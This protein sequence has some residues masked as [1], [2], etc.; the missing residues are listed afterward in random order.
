M[1]LIGFFSWENLEGGE[2]SEEPGLCFYRWL[3]ITV[4]LSISFSPTHSPHPW[5]G[6]LLVRVAYL[7]GDTVL[8]P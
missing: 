4:V 3:L 1:I 5:L 2:R 7:E 8:Y 6:P